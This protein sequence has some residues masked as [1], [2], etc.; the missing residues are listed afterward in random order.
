LGGVISSDR[1]TSKGPKK[2]LGENWGERVELKKNSGTY[3]DKVIIWIR[4]SG[5]GSQNPKPAKNC[6]VKRPKTKDK[7]PVGKVGSGHRN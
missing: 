5:G 7:L 3:H 6:Q 4:D 1:F 2:Y